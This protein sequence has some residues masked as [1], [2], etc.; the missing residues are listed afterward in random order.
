MTGCC[1]RVRRSWRR[2]T[3]PN[4]PRCATAPTRPRGCGPSRGGG[5]RGIRAADSRPPMASRRDHLLVT[6][7][8][9]L[10]RGFAGGVVIAQCGA[11]GGGHVCTRR[12]DAGGRAAGHAFF[13]EEFGDR[14]GILVFGHRGVLSLDERW[15]PS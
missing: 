11:V 8:L 12:Y 13:A 6:V 3:A 9:F 10:A 15:A 2:A 4:L 7:E 5:G 1:R 14:G